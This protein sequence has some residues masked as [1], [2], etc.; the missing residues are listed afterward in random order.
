M[1]GVNS[2]KEIKS[3]IKSISNTEHITKALEVV[4]SAKLRR[5]KNKL[6]KSDA[7]LHF[8]ANSIEEIFHNA[9]DVDSPYICKGMSFKKRCF[10][11][12]SSSSGLCGGFNINMVKKTIENI[13]DKE[14]D[15]IITIGSRGRDLLRGRGYKILANLEV[16]SEKGNF[17]DSIPITNE[18]LRLYKEHEFDALYLVY[19]EFKNVISQQP[20]IEL[21]LPFEIEEDYESMKHRKLVEYEPS[22]QEVLDYLVPK[23]CDV[24][25]YDGLMES[26]ASEHAAR[27]VAMSSATENADKMIS[28]LSLNY[29]RARQA[30]ITKEISEIVGGAEALK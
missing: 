22:A 30:A 18:I 19:T 28:E 9:I 20:I 13:K 14:N 8:I 26:F 1:S 6:D 16:P 29:N 12:I 25:V 15:Q 5:A 2:S 7:Y 17:V 24:M 3:R 21:L 11:V 27:R 10:V 23:Y 4:S